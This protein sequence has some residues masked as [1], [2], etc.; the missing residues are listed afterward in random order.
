V[1]KSFG[2]DE[3]VFWGYSVGGESS[4]LE[5]L[6]KKAPSPRLEVPSKKVPSPKLEALSK[7]APSP[8]KEF[9]F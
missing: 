2:L 7:K 3:G 1:G 5:V 4:G 8:K 6:S 9:Y